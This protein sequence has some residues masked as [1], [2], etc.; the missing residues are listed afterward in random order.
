VRDTLFLDTEWYNDR[1]VASLYTDDELELWPALVRVYAVGIT[2]H[3][4]LLIPATEKEPAVCAVVL[5][6]MSLDS[7][8]NPA[9]E[10]DCAA[11]LRMLNW[12]V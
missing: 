11:D 7:R 8:R 10:I 12:H 5:S 9:R 2:Q 3:K 4:Y 1:C 6:F